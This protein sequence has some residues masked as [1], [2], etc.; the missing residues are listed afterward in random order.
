MPQIDRLQILLYG[1]EPAL[2]AELVEFLNN[3]DVMVMPDVDTGMCSDQI[4]RRGVK[5]VFCDSTSE[6]R[7]SALAASRLQRLPVVVTSRLPEVTDWLDALEAG[8]ADYCAAPFDSRQI[9]WIIDSSMHGAYVT[10][11]A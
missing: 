8:A 11:A 7:A 1:L 5:L 9:N 2:A 10:A 4:A 3:H 6:C